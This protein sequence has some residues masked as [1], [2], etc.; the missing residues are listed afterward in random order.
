[1]RLIE[2][3]KMA[4]IELDLNMSTHYWVGEKELEGKASIYY[5]PIVLAYDRHYN[6]YNLENIPLLDARNLSLV[7][8]SGTRW[9][10]PFMNFHVEGSEEQSLWLCDFA[11]AGVTG[12]PYR[13]WLAIEGVSPV[14]FSR[15]SPKRICR[16]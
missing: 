3:G 5:G 16:I 6:N 1:M 13:S 8:T 4:I 12:T 7:M 15:D 10:E 2:S 14:P 11:S 9:I